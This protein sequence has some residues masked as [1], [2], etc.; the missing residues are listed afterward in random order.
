MIRIETRRVLAGLSLPLIVAAL[1]AC[2]GSS[3][4]GEDKTNTGDDST[5]ILNVG[6]AIRDGMNLNDATAPF[7]MYKHLGDEFVRVYFVAETMEPVTTEYG[8][9]LWPHFT[10]TEAPT[11]DV[12]VVSGGKGEGPGSAFIDWIVRDAAQAD[13]VTGHGDGVF[14]LAAAGLLSGKQAAVAP[15]HAADFAAAHPDVAQV[16]TT[17][18][19]VDD[20]G[21]VTSMGGLTSFESSLYV[22]EQLF[23]T[24]K[25]DAVAA[26][27]VFSDENRRLS[28]DP[29]VASMPSTDATAGPGDT[30]NVAI[31]IMDG[32]FITEAVAPYEVYKAAGDKLNVYLVG[33]TMD[34]ITGYYG[35]RLAPDYTFADA[36]AADVLVI[37]SGLGSMDTDLEN[38]AILDWVRS[39]AAGAEYVTSHCWGAFT[40][41]GAGLL[42]GKQATTFPGYFEQL[43]QLFPGIAEVV[44]TARIVRSGNVITS[45]GGLAAFEGSLYVVEDLYGAVEADVA[46]EATVFA[47]EN[48][49]HARNPLVG[50]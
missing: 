6:V 21:V 25:A 26:G 20:A 34:P 7:D 4:G 44:E 48:L 15:D 47:N 29:A 2:S 33:E 38:P 22:S 16:V 9:K 40:L 39:Q 50:E 12:L 19:F 24:E 45:N 43:S 23:G 37:P 32:L 27:L 11:S 28:V 3:S 10:I 8:A 41:G 17:A 5:T 46:A 49:Q 30:K 31:F 18:R 14:A 42:D 36:P 13:W 1:A 35:E